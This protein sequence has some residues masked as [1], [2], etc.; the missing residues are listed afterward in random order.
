[1]QH[2]TQKVTRLGTNAHGHLQNATPATSE[3]KTGPDQPRRAVAAKTEHAAAA[4]SRSC[5]T[6]IRS[7]WSVLAA[8]LGGLLLLWLA[9]T[10]ALRF[11][12]LDALRIRDALPLL[13]E[14]VRLLRRLASD[15]AMPWG[16]RVRLW[17]LLAYLALPFHL[18]PDFILRDRLG[19]RRRRPPGAQPLPRL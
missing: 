11:V 16:V 14:L 9:L 1:M 4:R 13:P 18:V 5:G 6:M 10:A 2:L 8:V 15:P 17:L 3:Q 19:R 7:W 12:S